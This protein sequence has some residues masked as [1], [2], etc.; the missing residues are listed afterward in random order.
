VRECC[1]VHSLALQQKTVQITCTEDNKAFIASGLEVY[2][3]PNNTRPPAV[4]SPY[5]ALYPQ[6][7]PS[8][9]SAD[10]GF[11]ADAETVGTEDAEA[12]DAWAAVA[13]VAVGSCVG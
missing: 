1:L 12:G 9:T 13:G 2:D 3:F 5:R 7:A 6:M 8:Q 4:A 11:A 10:A